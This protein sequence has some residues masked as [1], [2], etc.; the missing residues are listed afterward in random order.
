MWSEYVNAENVDSRIWP[1]N[2]AIA[3][4]FWSPQNTTDVES[5]YRRMETESVRLELLGL[6]QRTYQIPMVERMA[7]PAVSAQETA[8]LLTLVRA[9]E[10]VKDYSRESLAN[11]EPTSQTPLT[12]VVDAVSPESEVSRRF[13]IDV[14][15]FVVAGCKDPARAAELRAQLTS[16]ARN[17]ETVQSV[18]QRS[19]IVKDAA[20]ASAALSQAAVLA[21]TALDRIGQAL[22]MPDD[23]KK[24][25]IDALNAFET[26]AHK[27][28]LTI[29]ARGAF[30][31]LIEAAANGG[32]C[33]SPR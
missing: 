30:Q 33:V 5:M 7:G 9:L 2:A 1:R 29:P 19:Y 23:L 18:A 26:Q 25:Q 20:P 16:W 28:Q 12:R 27:S 24:Q 4:R 6:T 13:T 15:E 22:P 21:L 17:D 10:P 32:A 11:Q 14:D 31:K 3:E 8:A